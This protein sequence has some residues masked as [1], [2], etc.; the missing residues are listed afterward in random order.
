MSQRTWFKV[1]AFSPDGEF[2]P[3]EL[4]EYLERGMMIVTHEKAIVF[5]M[6]PFTVEYLDETKE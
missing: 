4:L 1:H 2:T 3:E 6:A 5:R